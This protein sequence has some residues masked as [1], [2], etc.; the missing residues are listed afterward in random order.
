MEAGYTYDAEHFVVGLGHLAVEGV[1][2]RQA[3]HGTTGIERTTCK[4]RGAALHTALEGQ[5]RQ[6]Y[7]RPAGPTDRAGQRRGRL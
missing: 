3:S 2:D 4:R 6:A 5:R 1:Q 7:E